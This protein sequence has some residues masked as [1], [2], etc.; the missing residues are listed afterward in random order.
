MKS[1]RKILIILLLLA[2]GSATDLYCNERFKFTHLTSRNGGLSYDAV[3]CIIQDSRGFIWIGTQKGLNRY[4]GSRF[5]IYGRDDFG[6]ESD[7]ISS[8]AESPDG[9]IWIGTDNGVI[10]Y[11]SPLLS[12]LTLIVFF[13]PYVYSAFFG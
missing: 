9:N 8:L 5:K 11:N 4:D 3:K 1:F 12:V 13:Y 6:V 10:I 2:G 7:H